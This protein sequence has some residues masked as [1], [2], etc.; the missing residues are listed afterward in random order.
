MKTEIAYDFYFLGETNNRYFFV[1]K[2][3]IAYEI[4]FK[5]FLYLFDD[6]HP[7]AKNTF[8]FVIAVFSN[9]T[10]QN[11]VL[12]KNIGITIAAIFDDFYKRNSNT[13]AVYICDSSDSKQLVRNR[14]FSHWFLAFQNEN[15]LKTDAI[16]I[17]ADGVAVPVSIIFRRDNPYKYQI[18]EAFEKLTDGLT[19]K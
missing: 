5:P 13:L 6:E 8:E 4:K 7:F 19:Q 12:D 10:S 1:T 18:M 16:L 11:P 3:D 9:P 17:S 15:Y 2:N 14:K